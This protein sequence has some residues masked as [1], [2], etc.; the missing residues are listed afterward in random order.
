MACTC[1]EESNT[2]KEFPS[3]EQKENDLNLL[4]IFLL[5]APYLHTE[6]TVSQSHRLELQPLCSYGYDKAAS[7]KLETPA[8]I[9]LHFEVCK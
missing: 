3:K 5:L 6:D 1:C 9:A 7:L 8:K 2:S 4:K